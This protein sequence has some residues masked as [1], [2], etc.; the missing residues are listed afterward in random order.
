M[1]AAVAEIAAL[2]PPAPV[3]FCQ[4]VVVPSIEISV[5]ILLMSSHIVIAHTPLMCVFARSLSR[6]LLQANFL[7]NRAYLLSTVLDCSFQSSPFT[8]LNLP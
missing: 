8:F 4:P 6:F 7:L 1:R 2:Q 3:A 5:D